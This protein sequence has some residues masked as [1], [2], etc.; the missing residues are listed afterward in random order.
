MKD[1]SGSCIRNCLLACVLLILA[2][3]KVLAGQDTATN[4]ALNFEVKK[5]GIVIVESQMLVTPGNNAEMVVSG[6]YGGE[7]RIEAN[8]RFAMDVEGVT[9]TYLQ[10]KLFEKDRDAWKLLASPELMAPLDRPAGTEIKLPAAANGSAT[11]FSLEVMKVEQ[12]ELWLKQ[13]S[14]RHASLFERESI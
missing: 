9:V 5:G 8:P 3:S 4:L 10:A 13:A 11:S 12:P 2:S 6:K 1:A 7:Y 14:D